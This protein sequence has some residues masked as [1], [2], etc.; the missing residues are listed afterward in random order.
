MVVCVC[1]SKELCFERT[2]NNPVEMNIIL[3]G[4]DRWNSISKTYTMTRNRKQIIRLTGSFIVLLERKKS[5]QFEVFVT[6]LV[7][8]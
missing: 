3:N 8:T 1:S 2:L 7:E 6:L 4:N 5:F